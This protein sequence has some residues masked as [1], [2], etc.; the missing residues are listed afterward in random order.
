MRGRNI[1]FAVIA[2]YLLGL[3]VWWAW[4]KVQSADTS[5]IAHITPAQLPKGTRTF[6]TSPPQVSVEKYNQPGTMV[7]LP[8]AKWVPQTFNNCG[9]ATTSM[10]LQYFGFNVGQDITK[11]AL[12]TN[13][14][15]TNVFS[16]EISDYLRTE[17]GIGSKVMWNGNLQLVKTL[18]ANGFY[19]MVE[20]WLHPNE[21]IGHN[22]IIRG[23]DDSEGV[24]ITDD[25]YT[26][27]GVKYK[28]EIFDDDQWKPFNREFM[29]VYKTEMEPLLRA[30]IG[31]NWNE[32]TM[33]ENSVKT[34]KA[35]V[36]SD[37]NDMYSWF[38]LG[39]SY[40]ALGNYTEARVAFEKSRSI[41]WPKR[42]LWYQYQPVQTYN[43][44]GEYQKAI[45]VA[46]LGLLNNDNY[47]EMH[48]E[49][50]VAYKGLND[51][52]RARE[53]AEKA[54]KAAPNWKPP[55]DFLKTL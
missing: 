24:I 14:S 45:E 13:P 6:P 18:L 44:L 17:F 26:G 41:G 50:A 23:Y 21:D 47:P 37:P 54:I 27:V 49:L 32:K 7:E 48:L 15:D 16:Y 43:K 42:M 55:Q 3:G 20:D 39:T 5:Y 46:G 38:N 35:A 8:A 53:E 10:L 40:Y 2:V 12:R 9:P 11:V 22:L 1:L 36:T 29:P 30:I 19:V 28:Y 52:A 25:S 34:N 4:P 31:E 33:H 51:N